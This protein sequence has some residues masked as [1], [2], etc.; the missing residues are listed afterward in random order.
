MWSPQCLSTVE[1]DTRASWPR[2]VHPGKKTRELAPK[3]SLHT[4]RQ[5]VLC[6]ESCHAIHSSNTGSLT[7]EA[8]AGMHLNFH[9][10]K[11]FGAQG[12]SDTAIRRVVTVPDKGS[13]IDGRASRAVECPVTKEPQPSALLLQLCFGL[14]CIHCFV[15][16]TGAS[17]IAAGPR[18]GS[19]PS[20]SGTPEHDRQHLCALVLS[21]KAGGVALALC[22]GFHCFQVISARFSAARCFVPGGS[23]LRRQHPFVPSACVQA[24]A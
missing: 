11:L 9:S 18:H 3:S 16:D 23:L 8:L 1:G 12:V 10:G 7:A 17:C 6:T 15:A 24:P 5:R 22:K 14:G 21:R 13:S 20:G 2:Q 19:N 4:Y